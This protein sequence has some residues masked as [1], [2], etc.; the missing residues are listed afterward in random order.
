MD[1]LA[2]IYLFK[3]NYWNTRKC[4]QKDAKSDVILV[5]L[6]LTLNILPNFS[7]ICAADFEQVN[8]SWDGQKIIKTSKLYSG[9]MKETKE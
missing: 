8:V 9:L 4:F 2:N 5:F 1:K 7:S 6:L 3:V